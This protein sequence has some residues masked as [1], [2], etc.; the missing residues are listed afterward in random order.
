MTD[1]QTCLYASPFLNKERHR[2]FHD[3]LESDWLEGSRVF[4][5]CINWHIKQV[6]NQ[7]GSVCR[8]KTPCAYSAVRVDDAVKGHMQLRN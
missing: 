4:K 8:S 3:I 5:T 2:R 6:D 7:R 1:H